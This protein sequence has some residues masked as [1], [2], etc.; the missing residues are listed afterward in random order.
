MNG[1]DDKPK[2]H[3]VLEQNLCS[4]IKKGETETLKN[5]GPFSSR[6]RIKSLSC[7][8]HLHSS[9]PSNLRNGCMPWAYAHLFSPS[10]TKSV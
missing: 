6:S 4:K 10:Q 9:A 1:P 8:V 2:D 3:Q 5:G 7:S